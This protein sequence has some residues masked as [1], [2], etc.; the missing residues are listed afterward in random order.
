MA[1]RR[2]A[3]CSRRPLKSHVLVVLSGLL[4]CA[5]VVLAAGP[6]LPNATAHVRTPSTVIRGLLFD[7]AASPTMSTLLRRLE[8]SDLIIYV[9]F[10]NSPEIPR[11]RTKLV[12]A[13]GA[14]RFLRI[15]INARIRPGD[16]LPILAHELQHAVEL[17]DAL[18]VRDDDGVRRL[19]TRIGFLC[20]PD[21]YETAAACA[22][23]H[24]VRCERP[25]HR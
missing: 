18:N 6:S 3:A 20:G 11:G 19:Y 24:E 15:D 22:V 8:A 9:V 4:L 25:K 5:D 2:S 21:R 23:E 7:A 12:T 16:R 14:A 1:L 10:T 17:A 13:T